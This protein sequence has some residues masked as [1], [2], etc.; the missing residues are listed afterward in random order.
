M[1]AGI[2]LID[3][4]QFSIEH[5]KGIARWYF[6]KN[7]RELIIFLWAKISECEHCVFGFDSKFDD[8][9]KTNADSIAS[10]GRKWGA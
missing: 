4:K 1:R 8:K 9:N 5:A 10:S 3:I 2:Q 6:Y 7:N